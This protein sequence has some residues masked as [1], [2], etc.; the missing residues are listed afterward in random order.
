MKFFAYD[1]GDLKGE[2]DIDPNDLDQVNEALQWYFGDW[3]DDGFERDD[4]GDE[5]M[6]LIDETCYLVNKKFEE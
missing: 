4:A 3:A 6:F 2:V 1:E 5:I